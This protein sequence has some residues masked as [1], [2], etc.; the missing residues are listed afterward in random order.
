MSRL[1]MV[2]RKFIENRLVGGVRV[3][4]GRVSKKFME[5]RLEITEGTS[6]RS[7]WFM[8]NRL[9]GLLRVSMKFIEKRLLIISR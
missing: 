1:S 2:S 8:E 6:T 7:K 4:E 5:N 3:A 9:L